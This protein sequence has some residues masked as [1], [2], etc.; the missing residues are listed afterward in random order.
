MPR[1]HDKADQR[2]DDAARAAW[3]YYVAGNTQEEIAE[4]MEMSRPAAQRLIS[5]AVREGLIKVRLDHPIAACMTLAAEL[6]ARF[7]L[8]TC[9]VVPS[10][11]AAGPDPI[12]VAETAAADIERWLSRDTTTTVAFGTGRTLRAV[13]DQLIS[14]DAGRH[15][16]VS[17]VGNISPD[18]SAST[19]DVISRVAERVSAPHFPLP[20]PVIASTEAEKRSLH[21]LGSVRQNLAMTEAADVAYVGI[22][23]VGEDAPL[24]VDGFLEA[25]ELAQLV[26]AGAAGEIIGWVFDADGKLLDCATNERVVSVPLHALANTPIVGVARGKTKRGALRAALR[27]GLLNGLIT[28]EEM[29]H[30]LLG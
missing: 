7:G 14:M 29:A 17:M 9:E 5:L 15:R 6:Q 3:L 13:A 2:L 16:I 18:G 23:Q 4:K 10:D 11:P 1:S 25:E 24:L 30:G 21:A 27:G 8:Q 22:G 28:D 19:Y 26:A 12:G 20:V